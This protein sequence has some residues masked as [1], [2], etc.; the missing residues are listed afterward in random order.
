MW[1]LHYYDVSLI[2]NLWFILYDHLNIFLVFINH[3]WFFDWFLNTV[4]L[5]FPMRILF[6]R[7]KNT[8]SDTPF[9]SPVQCMMHLFPRIIVPLIWNGLPFAIFVSCTKR[10]L[11]LYYYFK[12][13][14]KIVNLEGNPLIPNPKCLLK[15][16]YYHI[17]FVVMFEISWQ[18]IA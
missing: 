11:S 2:T 9:L 8:I 18:N 12:H 6:S 13:Q 4:L 15:K 7:R 1:R 17:S 14:C 5:E 3:R 16:V 10:F